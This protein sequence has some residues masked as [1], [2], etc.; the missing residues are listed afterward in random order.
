LIAPSPQAGKHDRRRQ[1]PDVAFQFSD[2]ELLLKWMAAATMVL[3]F[4]LL[5]RAFSLQ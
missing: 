5:L 3:T 2:I 4:A 1:L